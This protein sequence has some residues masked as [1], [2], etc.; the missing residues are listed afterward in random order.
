MSDSTFAIV[1]AG[2]EGKRLMPLTLDRAK[3]AVPFG[4]TY[5]LV[6]FALSNLVNAGYY[7]IAVL[8]QYKSHS[9]DRHIATTWRLS[10]LLG[11]YVATVPAQMRYGPR[12]F[13]GSA[14]AI[15]QSLNLIHDEQPDTIVVCGADHVYR[16]DPSQMVS[17][18]LESGAAVTVAGLRVPI[19]QAS[20]F[21]IIEPSGDGRRIARFVEKPARPRG[22][23][24][25]PDQVYASMGIYVFS[26]EALIES[27]TLDASDDDSKHDI[28]GNLIPALVD[29]GVA[30]VYDFSTNLIPGSTEDVH[31]YWRDVGTIDSYF[32]ASMDLL[33]ASPAFDL[34][35]R[36]WPILTWNHPLPPAK[37]LSVDGRD[38][39]ALDSLVCAGVVVAGG[40][41]RRS[42]LSPG[43][44]I[45][46]GAIVEESVMFND[47]EVGAGAT[48]RRAI[49]DKNVRVPEGATIGVDDDVDRARFVISPG[50]VVVVGKAQKVQ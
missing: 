17:A 40:T 49:L 10:P 21:G 26:A 1:L 13:S 6:D 23:A 43:V 8:T 18:H 14:D 32:D 20:S 42:V 35:N 27:V 11:N 16:M 38:G 3:P 2:G 12:W 25:A 19:E 30:C 22:L 28:G 48:V 45:G 44:R 24:D 36:R 31:A 46:P 33:S 37:F 7:R 9:L 29:Q 41:V 47:V 50:G 39:H 34:A 4:G 5:R 15:F